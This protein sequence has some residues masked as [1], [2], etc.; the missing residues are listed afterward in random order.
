MDPHKVMKK[1]RKGKDE[2]THTPQ[3]SL[4]K[5]ENLLSQFSSKAPV[6][7][8]VCH[9]KLLKLI[10]IFSSFVNMK[11]LKRQIKIFTRTRQRHYF[12]YHTA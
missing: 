6:S 2:A 5:Y 9:Q 12:L 11:K 7:T 1:S 10:Q 3:N 8:I 4:I